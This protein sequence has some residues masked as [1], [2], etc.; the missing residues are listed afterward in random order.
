MIRE[1]LLTMNE[2]NLT[3]DSRYQDPLRG[4]VR[5]ENQ[6]FDIAY[7]KRGFHTHESMFFYTLNVGHTF[8]YFKT[9]TDVFDYLASTK[10]RSETCWITEGF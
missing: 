3:W 5:I 10:E 7:F 9:I 6:K 1:L 2:Y 4:V 8:L